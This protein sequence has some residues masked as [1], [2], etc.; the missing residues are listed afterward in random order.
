MNERDTTINR[1]KTEGEKAVASS[2]SVLTKVYFNPS[3][4][5]TKN[6]KQ[7]AFINLSLPS[8]QNSFLG[9]RDSPAISFRSGRNRRASEK[10]IPSK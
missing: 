4:I 3:L 6:K 1:L 5:T 7:K 9:T 8:F 10:S 2:C